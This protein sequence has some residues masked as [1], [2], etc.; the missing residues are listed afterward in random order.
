MKIILMFRYTLVFMIVLAAV[1]CTMKSNNKIPHLQKQ[2]TATQ[3]IVNNKPFL[4]LGGEVANTASSSLDYMNKV[5]PNLNKLN[6]NTV[7]IGVAW[8]WVEPEEGKFDF[9]LVDGLLEGAR[10][11]NLKVVFIWFGSWKNG[12]SSFV[13]TWVKANQDRFPRV[14][15]RSGKSI[16]VLSTLSE[17]NRDSDTHAYTAFMRHIREV[18]SKKNTVLMIQLENEVGV[19]GDSRDHSKPANDAFAKSVPKEL[20]DYLI[21]NKTTLLPEIHKVWETTGFKTAGS[22]EEV[23][24]SSPATDEI[25][26]AWNYAKYMDKIAAAGKAEYPIPVF[27]NSWIV[28]PTDKVPG[29]YPSGGPEPL[30]LEIWRAGAT[31]IDINAP[32]IYLPNFDEWVALFN[33]N[34]NPL[35]VPESRGD[36]GGA[37]NAYYAIGQH[38]AIGYSPFGVDNTARLLAL[39]PGPEV[40]APEELEN[41]P[42]AKA[43]ATLQQLSSLILEHQGKGTIAGAWLNSNK[44]TQEIQLGNYK[45][46]VELWRDRRNPESIAELGYGIFIAVGPDEY[47][48]S[49][50]DIKVTFTPTTPGPPIAGLASVETGKFEKGQWIPDRKLSGDDILLRYDLG[51]AADVNQSGSGLQFRGFTHTIQR[52][53]LY[54]YK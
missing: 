13:P 19:L 40:K 9:S 44:Q 46:S 50:Y 10:S 20:M 15:V 36:L 34:G 6:F 52:V 22:W 38:A 25:F 11:H 49:G 26:M 18:D 7:L 39:R 2:G 16:E 32:D 17:T 33:R 37:A 12:I 3:L 14:Q 1:S 47:V 5:W 43:Y 27:T 23:F 48:I 35:F 53:K 21:K 31:H 24:G 4:I 28:Q 30:T 54:R 29:D 42:L 51:A 41:L 8:A 45:L